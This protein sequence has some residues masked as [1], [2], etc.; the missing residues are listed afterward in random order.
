MGRG[1]NQKS[2]GKKN[3][4]L[5]MLL[6][7]LFSLYPVIL[8]AQAT[9]I[10]ISTEPLPTRTSSFGR[11]TSPCAGCSSNHKG[12]DYRARTPTNVNTNA[13]VTSCSYVNGY[14]Y[15]AQVRR[16]CANGN[17]VTE[18]YAHLTRCPAN[19]ATSV[20]TG[21][22]GVGTAPHLHYN[23]LLGGT[24]VDPVAALNRD[25]CDNQVRSQLIED[26]RQKGVNGGGA[27]ATAPANP[28]TPP[29]AGG[30]GT[31]GVSTPPPTTVPPS[32]QPPTYNPAPWVDPINPQPM[33][34]TTDDLVPRT[35]TD[36]ELTGCAVDTWVAMVNQS[37]LQT[38]RE[39]LT[40]E[41]Y[42][43]K[44]DSVL[45]YSCFEEMYW[46]AGRTLGVFSETQ[47]WNNVQIDLS[48]RTTTVNVYMGNLSLDGAIADAVDSAVES[49]MIS[50]FN[51]GW[52]GEINEPVVLSGTG[53]NTPV[54]D[55]HGDHTHGVSQYN[56][57]CGTMRQVWQ[58]AKCLNIVDE[59]VFYKFEDLV[60]FDPRKFPHA[61]E[62][63]DSGIT[64]RMIDTAAHEDVAD[65]TFE[66]DD[67]ET[68]LDMIYPENGQC[69][70]PILTGVEVTV[71]RGADRVT[72]EVTY[73]DGLCITAGCSYQNPDASDTGTCEIR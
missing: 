4:S 41:R 17:T 9:S 20:L 44:A 60:G 30:T 16:T 45:A 23:V 72:E 43:A 69:A 63:M 54:D 8:Y 29:S 22:S 52:L 58:T 50:N 19:G 61:Y 3:I 64:Q 40:N 66:F 14:G 56:A 15:M 35:T 62:C 1:K 47:R 67:V 25:L 27:G 38:R 48:G 10:V 28:T 5:L 21:S 18:Q 59:P 12:Q 42:I 36:N 33:S 73:N 65:N 57:P 31:G 53:G 26:A 6:L 11:R 55:D 7:T 13:P 71:R 37:V 51:H 70:D 49:Y 39:M 24:N 32:P 34:P 2:A 68:Y 46:H